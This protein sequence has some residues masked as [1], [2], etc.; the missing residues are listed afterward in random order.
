MNTEGP[1]LRSKPGDTGRKCAYI[2]G[3]LYADFSS[4][5]LAFDLRTTMLELWGP[6]TN[7][8]PLLDRGHST[9][10]FVAGVL[11]GQLHAEHNR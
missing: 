11:P 9:R 4:P 5:T 1:A 6:L 2:T 7:S 8:S 3:E 10:P